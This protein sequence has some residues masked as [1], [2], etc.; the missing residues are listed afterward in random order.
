M[1]NLSKQEEIENHIPDEFSTA[2]QVLIAEDEPAIRNLLQTFLRMWGYRTLVASN[3]KQALEVFERHKGDID[4]LLSDVTMPEMDGQDLAE[5]LTRKRPSIKVILMSGFS[6]MHLALQR[7]WK[8]I[9]KPFK[10]STVKETLEEV[11]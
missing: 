1:S 9:Q 6:H 2:K 10:P 8:F 3:G 5:Q 4:V 7:G 11:L